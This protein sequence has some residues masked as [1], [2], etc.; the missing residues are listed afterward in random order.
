MSI[1]VAPVVA[2]IG[3]AIRVGADFEQTMRNVQSVS[4]ATGAEF[5]RLTAFAKQMGETTIFTA[6]ESGDALYYLASAGY[7]AQ[8]QMSA[9]PGILALAAATQADL[10][11]T[12]E[13]TV[14]TIN[15]FNLQA[16]DA[17]RVANTFAAAIGASQ[18]TMERLGVAMPYVSSVAESLNISFEE[19]VATLGLLTSSGI[20]AQGAGRLLA[21]SLLSLIDITPEAQEVLDRV[22]LTAQDV[23]PSLHS[24]ADI[25]DLLKQKQLSAIDITRIFG[26]EGARVW[27]SLIPKGGDAIRALTDRITGTNAAQEMAAIQLNSLSGAWKL[28]NSMIEGIKISIFD[29]VK[30]RLGALVVEVQELIP[31]IK[32]LIIIF[33]KQ[34]VDVIATV[35]E[36]G[37]AIVR[38]FKNLSDGTKEAI[39]KVGALV[40]GFMAL[41]GPIGVLASF[42]LPALLSPIGLIAMGIA[43]LSIVIYKF[44]YDIGIAL[45]K[46]ADAVLW[47]VETV[48]GAIGSF[49]KF[50]G[51]DWLDG[52][53]EAIAGAR[54]TM[55]RW[56]DEL[57]DAKEAARKAKEEHDALAASIANTQAA[58]AAAATPERP[59]QRTERVIA[60]ATVGVE[61]TTPGR[62]EIRALGEEAE[63]ATSTLLDFYD[64]QLLATDAFAEMQDIGT[65]AFASIGD[66]VGQAYLTMTTQHKKF[67]EAFLA[68]MQQLVNQMISLLIAL[69][70]KLAIA[71]AL[72]QITGIDWGKSLALVG[73]PGFGKQTGGLHL[74]AGG[75]DGIIT[76]VSRGELTLSEPMTRE[77]KRYFGS[78]RSP[79][80]AGAGSGREIHLHF[81]GYMIDRKS[82]EDALDHGELGDKIRAAVTE[83]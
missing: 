10:A 6:R 47:F 76:R 58:L 67:T 77:F 16:E 64:T 40:G 15:A 72:M 74:G 39:A 53:M 31:D 69:I 5:E 51:A 62:G 29:A 20:K 28:L 9:L 26:K 37:L 50:F 2:A 25:V 48:I 78:T 32:E 49:L 27:L 55:A 46:A 1:A 36:K 65:Q 52:T 71:A 81:E 63:I 8:K 41:V 35:V 73:L 56:E 70:A 24:L 11:S 44:R 19:S 17:S 3:D 45:T 18:L 66:A 75:K 68:G 14:S 38:W 57:K 22:R 21:S 23:N 54:A 34:F 4:G 82:L 59:G 30:A 12:S 7:S 60:G 80:A 79:V 33:A 61:A 43:A 42:V 13:I 83:Y